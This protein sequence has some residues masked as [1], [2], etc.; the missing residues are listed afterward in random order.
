MV[1]KTLYKIG[2]R[3]VPRE[4]KTI[5]AVKKGIH[6]RSSFSRVSKILFLTLELSSHPVARLLAAALVMASR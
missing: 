4:E 5:N 2:D 3:L 1:V 6:R